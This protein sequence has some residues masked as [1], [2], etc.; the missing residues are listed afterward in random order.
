MLEGKD[1]DPDYNEAA[2]P[3][4]KRLK[5]LEDNGKYKLPIYIFMFVHDFLPFSARSHLGERVKHILDN[6]FELEVNQ[7][8]NEI[9]E[10]D[11]CIAKVQQKL[12]IL[13]YVATRSFFS[14]KS[15]VCLSNLSSCCYSTHSDSFSFLAAF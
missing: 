11:K 15:L 3:D 2:P 8:H 10:I 5:H 12:Q 14:P 6:H 13:R 4:R 9:Q 7:Q 1:Q